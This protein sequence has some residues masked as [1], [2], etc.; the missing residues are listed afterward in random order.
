MT[1]GAS[2][3][4]NALT[5]NVIPYRNL[6]ELEEKLKAG[7]LDKEELLA[8]LLDFVSKDPKR[9]S[10]ELNTCLNLLEK[11]G[12]DSNTFTCSTPTRRSE[13]FARESFAIT[14]LKSLEKVTGEK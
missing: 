10:A 3:V 14:S 12:E 6:P 4:S 11:E 13:N 9:A 1:V 5:G 7:E 2:I 8:K